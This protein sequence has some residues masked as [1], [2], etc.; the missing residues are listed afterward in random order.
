MKYDKNEFMKI[1]KSIFGED[2]REKIQVEL[3]E[4]DDLY[5]DML[6][7]ESKMKKYQKQLNSGSRTEQD[8]AKYQLNRLKLIRES[9]IIDED[10]VE[11]RE[12]KVEVLIK[13]L[14]PLL[15][16]IIYNLSRLEE[17]KK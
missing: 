7:I 6:R 1:Y 9:Y 14:A 8:E 3:K 4:N 13:N 10:S 17:M 12:A 16:E 2:V 11:D 5:K 15:Q